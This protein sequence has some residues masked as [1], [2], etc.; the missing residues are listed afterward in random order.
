[1]EKMLFDI[2]RKS[3]DCYYNSG[4][5]YEMSDEECES[6]VQFLHIPSQ[7]VMTDT[8]YDEI[9]FKAK[10]LYPSNVYFLSIGSE[11]RGDKVDL[12]IPLGSMVEAKPGDLVPWIVGGEYCV[13]DK[14]DGISCLLAYENGKLK[15]AYSRGDGHQG[16]DITRHLN[17]F[18]YCPRTLNENF[19]GFVRGE[20]IIPKDDIP[21]TISQLLHDTGKEY[22]NGR[23]L[24]AGQLNAKECAEV[25][26][27]NTHFV[28]YYIDG[29][30]GETF[31]MFKQ[32]NKLG[33]ETP[34]F[35]VYNSQDITDDRMMRD[36]S[37]VKL[38]GK[39]ECD[40]II[41]TQNIIDDEHKG[42]ETSSL[43]PKASRKFKISGLDETFTSTIENITWQISKDWLLKPVLNITPTDHNGV[44]I[45]NISGNN[46]KFI[47]DNDLRIGTVIKGKRSGD[48]IP[49]YVETIEK[50]TR[51][52]DP[53]NLAQ[54]G[55]EFE[56]E[57]V[58]LVF[59]G[60]ED[61][62]LDLC[63]EAYTQ[64]TLY[65]CTKLGVEFG[66][67]GNIQK[68]MEETE[69]YRLDYKNLCSLPKQVFENAIGV[70]GIKF[71]E[72]LHKKIESATPTQ[73]ADACGCFGRGIGELKLNKIVDNYGELIFD[74]DKILS[75]DGWADKTTEQYMSR[76]VNYINMVEFFQ[77]IES[78]KGYEEATLS[79]KYADVKVVFTGVR[80]ADLEN[81]IRVNGGKILTSCT[82]E[83]NLVV[84]RDPLSSSTKL[85]KAR[86][87]GVEII[88]LEE[89]VKRF[90]KTEQAPVKLEDLDNP[91][92]KLLM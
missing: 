2:L 76:Y 27:Y 88:S 39:Y 31:E 62:Y 12:P 1:M 17:R 69:N 80:S 52:E 92:A 25:F 36:L 42:F 19:T 43:N 55:D 61:N 50:S 56:R 29:W 63:I 4:E 45:S 82:K 79:N 74:E 47:I 66:G 8:L 38:F 87:R 35:R 60:S 48:V 67:Y 22:K 51:E 33:F 90:G 86:E 54:F 58:E 78:W 26:V 46:Y 44:T 64:K 32:L 18:Q 65:F 34:S 84:A 14:L 91:L 10:Q 59:I 68:L 41:I 7:K 15:I 40:G 3:A 30:N 5:Y 85:V 75:T 57:G 37:A 24:C 89:A 77:K 53:Y 70:N 20:V 81:I 23:N 11:V 71:Y 73:L 16:Q 49:Q 6:I 83:C 13:S 72:S 21:F 9:Y 28:A